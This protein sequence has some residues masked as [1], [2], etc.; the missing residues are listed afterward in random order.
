MSRNIENRLERLEAAIK[1]QSGELPYVV[2]WPEDDTDEQAR[3]AAEV[4][5]RERAGQ[6]CIVV[7]PG[8]DALDAL[9]EHF[10]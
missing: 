2:Q 4:A 10:L 7:R 1:P 6:T 8:D 5:E 9:V 3:A